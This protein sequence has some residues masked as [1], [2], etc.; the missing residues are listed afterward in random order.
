MVWYKRV[1]EKL[2]SSGL[3]S[4]VSLLGAK[5]RASLAPDEAAPPA[6]ANQ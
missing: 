5:V 4:E 6:S 2:R 1:V 3:F